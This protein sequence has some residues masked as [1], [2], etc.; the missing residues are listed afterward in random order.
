MKKKSF[1]FFLTAVLFA[2]CF[3]LTAQSKSKRV[4]KTVPPFNIPTDLVYVDISLQKPPAISVDN[5][6]T[7]IGSTTSGSGYA[8]QWLVA[9]ITFAFSIPDSIKSSQ[10]VCHENLRIELFLTVPSTTSRGKVEYSWFY[11]AQVLHGVVVDPSLKEQKYMVSL[12][13]PPSYVYMYFP[14]DKT[15]KYNL[16]EMEGVVLFFDKDSVLIGAKAF[17]V[18]GK[19]SKSRSSQLIDAVGDLKKSQKMPIMLWPREKTPWQWI[20][21]DRFELPKTEFPDVPVTTTGGKDEGG[22]E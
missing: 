16:K 14:K 1:I 13:M 5:K 22:T 20:D 15:D 7:R 9:E 3:V 21:S 8:K 2:A 10:P 19:L 11:G 17:E 18:K 6:K 4:S 12:F